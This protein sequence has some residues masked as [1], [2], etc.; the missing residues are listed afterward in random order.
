MSPAA[1]KTT[2]AQALRQMLAVLET[3]RQALAAMDVDALVLSATDKHALL[4]DLEQHGRSGVDAE[5][6]GLL[7]AARHQNEVNRKV[8][9]LL[10]ANV[11]QRLDMLTR[12]P[13]LYTAPQARRA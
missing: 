6:R 11:A 1:M 13:G 3:E 7:E 9:N 12:N 10:A 8:R 2:L 5:C 4:G